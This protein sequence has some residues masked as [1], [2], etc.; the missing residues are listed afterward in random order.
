MVVALAH[1]HA[2]Q[3][4]PPALCAQLEAINVD[5]AVLSI[6]VD[7]SDGI[8]SDSIAMRKR[9]ESLNRTPHSWVRGTE[10]N[11]NLARHWLTDSQR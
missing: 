7:P 2:S 11:V 4:G 5:S 6:S 8:A 1:Q 3:A 10:E 9:H